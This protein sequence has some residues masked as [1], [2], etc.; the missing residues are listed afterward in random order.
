[1]VWDM[2][3]KMAKKIHVLLWHSFIRGTHDGGSRNKTKNV[4]CHL[5][6]IIIVAI[7]AFMV[8]ELYD[9][10][11]E[12]YQVIHQLSI[13]DPVRKNWE[14]NQ[15][16][17]NFLLIGGAI[18]IGLIGLF[19]GYQQW[20]L[21]QDILN[22]EDQQKYMDWFNHQKEEVQKLCVMNPSMHDWKKLKKYS[23][24]LASYEQLKSVEQQK[25]LT[26]FT[27]KV[28]K[29]HTIKRL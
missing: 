15:I 21:S 3:H 28:S 12:R 17:R 25:E 27:Q 22:A 19:V 11:A 26:S 23:Q 6:W 29:Q 8:W 10:H 7:C 9:I 16:L 14:A 5:T 18:S 20:I 1:M 2:C 24:V 13:N 4:W